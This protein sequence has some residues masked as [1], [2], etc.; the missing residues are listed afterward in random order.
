MTLSFLN[1]EFENLR[2]LNKLRVD[3]DVL[4]SWQKGMFKGLNG[5][6]KKI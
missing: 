2:N 3:L 4:E 6:A 5:L 1:W